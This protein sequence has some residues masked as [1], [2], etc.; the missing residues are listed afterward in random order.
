MATG[1]EDG[2]EEHRGASDGASGSASGGASG[3]VGSGNGGGN[4]GEALPVPSGLAALAPGRVHEATGPGRRAFAAALAGAAGGTGEAGGPGGT[5]EAGGPGGTGEAGGP[6]GTVLWI[7]DARLAETFCPAGLAPLLDPARLVLARPSGLIAALQ[8]AEEALRSG[9]V[10]LVVAELEAAPD[11]TQSRRLQLAAGTGGG[12]GLC[13]VPEHRLATNAAE[14]RWHCSPVAHPRA[15]GQG[16]S[17]P[18]GALQHWELVKNRRG[19]LGAWQV[20]LA[21]GTARRPGTD[22]GQ[23]AAVAA[24]R[25]AA[26]ARTGMAAPVSSVPPARRRPA[27]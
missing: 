1:A 8:V 12:R 22:A 5:G 19:P 4:G 13:L 11:L 6:G 27:G 26:H 14:T 20:V 23:D 17:L 9:A 18:P 7:L 15:T 21:D 16:S 24:L 3:A 25:P 10:P 2:G